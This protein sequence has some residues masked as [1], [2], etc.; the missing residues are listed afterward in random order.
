MPTAHSLMR[1]DVSSSQSDAEMP[2]LHSLMQRDVNSSPMRPRPL[3]NVPEVCQC[4]RWCWTL[5]SQWERRTFPQSTSDTTT[6]WLPSVSLSQTTNSSKQ[7]CSPCPESSRTD[8]TSPHLTSSAGF[9]C[10][11]KYS[12]NSSLSCATTASTWPLLVI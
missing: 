9:Q 3:S 10:I 8:H 2:T 1:K 12:T 5:R 6:V 11:H 7:H 4:V